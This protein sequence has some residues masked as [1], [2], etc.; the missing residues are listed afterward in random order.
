[1][2]AAP[3]TRTLT[4]E[5]LAETVGEEG[6]EV[7]FAQAL[8]VLAMFFDKWRLEDQIEAAAHPGAAARRRTDADAA[9]AVDP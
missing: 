5:V 4:P 1:M 2:P 3:V 8:A 7:T 9:A 6:K